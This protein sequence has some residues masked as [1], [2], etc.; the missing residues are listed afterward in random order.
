MTEQQQQETDP[1]QAQAEL[2]ARQT[3]DQIGIQSQQEKVAKRKFNPGFFDETTDLDLSTE[4]FDW[5]ENELGAKG[6]K[7]QT[8]GNRPESFAES[9]ELLNRNQA[10]RM[11][12]EREPGYLVKKNPAVNAVWQGVES[13]GDADAVTPIEQDR[14]RRQYRDMAEVLTTRETLAIDG[15]FVDALTKATTETHHREQTEDDASQ[16]T[17]RLRSM[18]K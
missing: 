16:T 18:F 11:I 17:K 8:L 7:A 14:V 2:S 1:Y 6:S 13:M 5:L 9:Q 15:K 12:A 4:L 10:E 3:A